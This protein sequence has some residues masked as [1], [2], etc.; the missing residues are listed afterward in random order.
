MINYEMR[1]IMNTVAGE[2][3]CHAVQTDEARYMNKQTLNEIMPVQT[4]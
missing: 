1:N 2:I 3:Q 4:F